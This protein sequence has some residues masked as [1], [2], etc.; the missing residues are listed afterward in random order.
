MS[1]GLVPPTS[2]PTDPPTSPP[3]PHKSWPRRH[4]IAT[5]LLSLGS[6][7][8]VLIVVGIIGAAVG[9]GKT[10]G[11][12]INTTPS[13]AAPVAATPAAPA[14]AAAPN[15]QG[16]Y[17]G[18]CDYTLSS[19]LYGNDH[20]IGEIDLTNTGN[21][22]TITRVRITWPQEGYVPITARK[23]VHVPA[24]QSLP[25]RFHIAVSSQGNV[26]TQLQSYQLSHNGTGCTYHAAIVSTFGSV[27]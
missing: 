22:G 23:T 14:P 19:S 2:P 10:A 6:L 21:I 26:I 24:G 13:A 11:V 8:V 17:S 12:H 7:V 20:L 16:N 15:P 5:I 27:H 9:T 25:V 3:E 18:S 4:K 1:Y